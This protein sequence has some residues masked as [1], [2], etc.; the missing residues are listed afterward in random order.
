MPL[1]GRSPSEMGRSNCSDLQQRSS[2]GTVEVVPL[3]KTDRALRPGL[4]RMSCNGERMHRGKLVARM[5]RSANA[6]F[7][8]RPAVRRRQVRNSDSSQFG[9]FSLSLLVNGN[10][11]IG[12]LP[13]FQKLLIRLL[14]RRFVV[15]RPTLKK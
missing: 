3:S 15:N 13:E 4:F 10:V 14:C 2:Y 9:V 5:P 8:P 6:G 12:V 1:L 11:R 7:G